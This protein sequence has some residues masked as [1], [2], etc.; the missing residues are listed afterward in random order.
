MDIAMKRSFA[1]GIILS[2][3]VLLFSAGCSNQASTDSNSSSI[4]ATTS[5]NIP[6]SKADIT[7]MYIRAIGDYINLV[8]TEY[9]IQFD[10]LLF[11]KHVHGQPDD[12][13]DITLP[14]TIGNVQI[15]LISM[16]QA[17]QNQD[18]LVFINM[19]GDVHAESS[20]FIFVTFLNGFSHSFD[21]FTSYEYISGK[22]D[23]DLINSRF[24]AFDN[25]DIKAAANK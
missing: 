4:E 14:D 10:T 22:N 15:R 16:E 9:Q 8:H 19:M 24:K 25:R 1:L 21:C 5:K 11:G 23:F 13:P 12:F 6:P 3:S 18:S 17:A 20:N 7:E 2:F